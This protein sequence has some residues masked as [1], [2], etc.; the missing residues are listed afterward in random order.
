M[1]FLVDLSWIWTHV[2]NY[3]RYV[4]NY[5]GISKIMLGPGVQ[6]T[7]CKKQPS[8]SR[9]DL[10][11][12]WVVQTSYKHNFPTHFLHVSLIFGCVENY[13]LGSS[14]WVHR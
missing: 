8:T 13:V 7:A 14:V 3:I 1:R 4:D 2:D 5:L 11:H 6:K 10:D 12:I 9:P